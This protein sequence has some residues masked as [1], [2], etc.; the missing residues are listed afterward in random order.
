MP[1]QTQYEGRWVDYPPE[2]DEEVRDYGFALSRGIPTVFSNSDSILTAGPLADRKLYILKEPDWHLTTVEIDDLRAWF[3]TKGMAPRFFFPEVMAEGFKDPNHA[4]YSAKLATAVAAW[5][6]VKSATKG[7]SVKQ[8]LTA[9]IVSNG[10]KYGLGGEQEVVSNSI[11][12]EIATIANWRTGGGATPT[13]GEVDETKG[14][15]V[16]E[17]QN[18]EEIASSASDYGGG[19]SSFSAD[20]DSDIPF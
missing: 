17:I 3:R 8:T 19:Y 11:A 15:V 13:S 9:W 14:E 2:A 18:F 1:G 5:E 10:V 6:T 7:N 12:E 16:T 20:D 4:R